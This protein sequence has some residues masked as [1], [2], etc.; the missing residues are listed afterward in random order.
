MMD[1]EISGQKVATNECS[2]SL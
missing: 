2:G 1:R